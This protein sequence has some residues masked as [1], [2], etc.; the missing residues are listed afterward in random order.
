MTAA[1][2]IKRRFGDLRPGLQLLGVVDAAIP[3]TIVRPARS[4]GCMR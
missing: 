2:L 3:V 1:A 4:S